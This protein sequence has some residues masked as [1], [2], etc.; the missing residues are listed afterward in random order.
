MHYEDCSQGYSLDKETHYEELVTNMEN[1]KKEIPEGVIKFF[2]NI[3]QNDKILDAFTGVFNDT[4][5]HIGEKNE[6]DKERHKLYVLIARYTL[7]YQIEYCLRTTG[8]CNINCE[9]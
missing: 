6:N 7:G 9:Y 4:H 5:K 1:L 8:S 3:E 2:E